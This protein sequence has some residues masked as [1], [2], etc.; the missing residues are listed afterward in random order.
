VAD[1]NQKLRQA[2]AQKMLEL[3]VGANGRPPA[4]MKEL[5]EWM[6]SPEGEAATAYDTD[7]HG[8]I[9]PDLVE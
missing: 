1:D 8:Q 3:Y 9:I 7:P 2:R 6:A 5:A 4:N